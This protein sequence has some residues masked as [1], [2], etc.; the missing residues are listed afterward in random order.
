[1]NIG[2]P[3]PSTFTPW[4]LMNLQVEVTSTRNKTLGGVLLILINGTCLPDDLE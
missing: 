1:M 4:T 3:S 2:A